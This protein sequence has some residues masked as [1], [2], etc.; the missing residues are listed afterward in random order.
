MRTLAAIL[1]LLNWTLPVHAQAWS[2]IIA[3]AR[4]VNWA[5]VGVPGGNPQTGGLP[6]DSWTQCTNTACTTAFT[7]PTAANINTA[8]AGA[9]AHTYVLLPAGTFSIGSPGIVWNSVSNV[10]VRGVGSNSTFLV[11]TAN[12]ICQGTSADVCMESAD[13]N[14]QGGPSNVSNWTAG[15]AQGATTITLSSVPNLKV[16]T[17]IMLD[18]VDDAT[19]TGQP[20]FTCGFPTTCATAGLGGYTR[21]T[22]ASNSRSQSQLVTVTQCDG[23]STPGHACSS[24]TNITISP[25]LYRNNWDINGATSAPQAWWATSPCSNDGIRNVSMNHDASDPLKGVEFFNCANGWVSGVRST[26]S[27][28][29][30]NTGDSQAHVIFW[31]SPHG[32][33]QNSYF[34]GNRTTGSASVLYG[35]AFGNS[36]DTLVQNNIFEY[37]QAPVPEDGPCS[38][39]V[40]AYNF[41]VNNE[42]QSLVFQ[43]QGQFAHSVA[44]YILYEGNQ[45]AGIYMDNFHGTHYLHTVF[46]NAYNGFQQNQGNVTNQNTEPILLLAYS[47]FMNI[48]G[49]VLGSPALPHNKYQTL[50]PTVPIGTEIYTL[51]CGDNGSICL[52]GSIPNDSLTSTSLMR[53]GNYDT[54][55]AAVRWCGNSSD[56]GW[57]TTCSSTSEVPTGDPT[58]PNTVP[59]SLTLPASFYLSGKPSWWPNTIPYPPTGP[60]VTSGNLRIC[61][62]G[63]NQGA[64]VTA[65]G[66]CPSSTLDTL[67]GFANANPAM[68]CFLN[69]MGGS[70][71]GTDSSALAFNSSACYPSNSVITAPPVPVPLLL[72]R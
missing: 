24:G 56:P 71:I 31:N 27:K 65:S 1:L 25:G 32:T 64:Y 40:V 10:E 58:F 30:S 62:G 22:S 67:G 14:Y 12:N 21:G 17:P 42:F 66:Q 34:Y 36:A 55:T 51:N 57:S 4:A 43:N 45:G 38:G 8:I 11:F 28:A 49:N 2:G 13:T 3:P 29:P 50:A 54:V 7:T 69:T 47:R 19:D 35:V 59:A 52:S 16:G 68:N 60:D 53:W 48:I 33:V 20:Q 5:N 15:Y 23:N 41:D 37:V 26:Y 44:D 9:P 46:R 39:C 6:S 18:Q 72:G 63:T 61:H 70:P